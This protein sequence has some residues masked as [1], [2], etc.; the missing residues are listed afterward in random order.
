M[1]EAR[2]V[3]ERDVV[4]GV[5]SEAEVDELLEAGE[6]VAYRR[7]RIVREVELAHLGRGEARERP[8]AVERPVRVA[9]VEARARR[10]LCEVADEARPAAAHRT[11]REHT[12]VAAAR[13]GIG[14][15]GRRSTP[16]LATGGCGRS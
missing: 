16:P 8:E 11:F 14:V 7:E 12:G 15:G 10:N 1:L 6:A 9:E 5:A 4:D 2:Q 13:L 3:V